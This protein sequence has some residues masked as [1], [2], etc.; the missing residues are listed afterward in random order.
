MLDVAMPVPLAAIDPICDCAPPH[1]PRR[2]REVHAA[3]AAVGERRPVRTPTAL[4]IELHRRR[5][6]VSIRTS[7]SD[8]VA[9]THT[10]PPGPAAT[11]VGPVP[12]LKRPITSPAGVIRA[13]VFEICSATQKLPS[14]PSAIPFVADWKALKSWM[15]RGAGRSRE[16]EAGE[17]DREQ[18]PA[19]HRATVP[20]NEDPWRPLRVLLADDEVL[21]SA[22]LARLLEDAGI[23]V[24]ATVAR[25]DEVL[26]RASTEHR[27]D[28]AII[29]VQ[30]PPDRHRRRAARRDRGARAR[31]RRRP[32]SCSRTS[33]RSATRST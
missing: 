6:T 33:S 14:G 5:A 16:R 4:S 29:D 15:T 19:A 23:E 9:D 27:P 24:V 26:R 28:V 25:A 2:Q 7:W 10:V 22:G 30:M 18:D 3:V 12:T 13:T 8:P 17:G 20:H 1:D 11:D 32:C 31:S 21:L